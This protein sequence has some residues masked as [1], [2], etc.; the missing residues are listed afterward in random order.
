MFSTR[1]LVNTHNDVPSYWVFQYYLNLPEVL[2]GQAVKIKS[3]FNANERTPSMCIYVDS[4]RNEYMFKDF[5]TGT[6]GSKIDLVKT[7]FSIDYGLA[8]SKILDDYNSYVKKNGSVDVTI[9]PA[10]KWEIDNIKT[11]TWNTDDADYWLQFRIGT[12]LLNKYNVKPLEYY[13]MVRVD[14]GKVDKIKIESACMYGYYT[15]DG[16]LYKVYKP[17]SKKR[18]FFRIASHLQGLDQLEY[19]QPYLVICSSL[20]DAMCLEGFGYNIEVVAPESETSVIKPIYIESFKKRYKKIITLFD[21]DDAGHQAIERYKELY[22]VNGCALDI[23]KD[24][25]DAVKDHGFEKVHT[26]LKPLLKKTIY[27]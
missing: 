9:N 5:S 4:S 13:N 18:K 20:K 14:N 7:I 27:E 3:I 8:V 15:K 21:S 19:N 2:T 22:D 23:A 25:S 16:S 26:E 10:A 1:N 12:S 24:I 11:R 6:Y 17:K